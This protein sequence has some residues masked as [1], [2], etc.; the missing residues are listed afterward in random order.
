MS[1]S[2]SRL[3]INE[4]A[5]RLRR[6]AAVLGAFLFIFLRQRANDDLTYIFYYSRL[7]E[8]YITR[9]WGI[10]LRTRRGCRCSV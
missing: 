1:Y 7:G 2:S 10:V 8:W 5:Y 4:S 3:K 6:I 9:N